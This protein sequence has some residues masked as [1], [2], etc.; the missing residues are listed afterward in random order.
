MKKT[1]IILTILTI[2]L[3][4]L[5]NLFYCSGNVNLLY[6]GKIFIYPNLKSY[7]GK[8]INSEKIPLFLYDFRKNRPIE[9]YLNYCYFLFEKDIN[10]TEEQKNLEYNLQ[11]DLNLCLRILNRTDIYSFTNM[12]MIS[13]AGYYDRKSGIYLDDYINQVETTFSNNKLFITKF[14]NKVKQ[15]EE[16]SNKIIKEEFPYPDEG[17]ET[18]I[19]LYSRIAELNN[20][21]LSILQGFVI[22]YC[23]SKKDKQC[24]IFLYERDGKN[25]QK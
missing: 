20:D 12:T 11:N 18:H 17:R 9:P 13:T 10:S 6:L 19:F 1:C 22:D 5:L 15:L 7:K 21:K 24:Q 2:F 4:I 16:L 8:I 3:F 14:R 23:I 25:K